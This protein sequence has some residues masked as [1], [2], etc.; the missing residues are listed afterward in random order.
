MYVM[1]K[2]YGFQVNYQLTVYI[3]MISILY[4]RKL[5]REKTFVNFVVLGLSAKVFL[6]EI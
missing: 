3:G 1:S 5:E 2:K 4:S 6:H